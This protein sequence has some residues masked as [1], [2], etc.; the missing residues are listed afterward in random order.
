LAHFTDP[1]LAEI[2]QG[3]ID[4]F[5]THYGSDMPTWYPDGMIRKERQWSPGLSLTDEHWDRNGCMNL[6]NQFESSIRRRDK[7]LLKRIEAAEKSGDKNLLARLLQEKQTS[8]P[9]NDNGKTKRTEL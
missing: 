6:I 7:V 9:G 4:H 5:Q 8:G 3:I 2:G 1:V